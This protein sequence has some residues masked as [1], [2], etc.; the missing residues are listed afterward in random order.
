MATADL[1]NIQASLG[2]SLKVSDLFARFSS[3]SWKN[4]F[5][6]NPHGLVDFA[7]I[8]AQ[9]LKWSRHYMEVQLATNKSRKRNKNVCNKTLIFLN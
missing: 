8:S 3:D 6:V 1:I 7:I 4:S 2:A 5:R 9:I